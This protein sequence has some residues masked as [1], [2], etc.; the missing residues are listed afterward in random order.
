M[1]PLRNHE[2]PTKVDLAVASFKGAVA[3]TRGDALSTAGGLLTA[4]TAQLM[5]MRSHVTVAPESAATCIETDLVLV[6][7][8]VYEPK[9]LP[10]RA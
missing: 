1:T 6:V 9:G 10:A 8:P 7:K 5:T 3:L 4:A 2:V